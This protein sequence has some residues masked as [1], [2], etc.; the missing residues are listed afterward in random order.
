MHFCIGANLARTELRTVFPALFRRF[1]R[2]R[3]AVDLDDIEVRT[4]RL[5]GGLNE[6]R[7]TW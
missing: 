3:L 4:D 2:L 7:V 6:V 1:P 5:T